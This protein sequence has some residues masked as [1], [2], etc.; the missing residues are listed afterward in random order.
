MTIPDNVINDLIAQVNEIDT[1]LGTDPAGVYSNVR[2][3]L[4]ILE[5]RVN[6]PFNPSPSSDFA[7]LNL[8]ELS[9][10]P[11]APDDDGQIVYLLSLKDA[12]VYHAASTLTVDGI[13]IVAANGSG[14]WERINLG[15]QEWRT[16]NTWYIDPTLGNDENN[17]LTSGTALKT[18]AELIRRWGPK[19]DIIQS[20]NIYFLGN[21]PTSDPI[22]LSEVAAPNNIL[23]NGKLTALATGTLTSYAAQVNNVS[24]VQIG[25]AGLVSTGFAPYVGKRLRFTSGAA[26]GMYV[27]IQ[28]DDGYITDGYKASVLTPSNLF[29]FANAA[30]G[31]TYVIEDLS[32]VT[33]SNISAKGT[34]D[35]TIGFVDLNIINSS[36]S[37]LCTTLFLNSDLRTSAIIKSRSVYLQSSTAPVTVT[38]VGILL[39]GLCAFFAQ[40]NVSGSFV[41]IFNDCAAIGQTACMSL[42][43]AS[44]VSVT[45]YATVSIQDGTAGFIVDEQSTL[46]LSNTVW[47]SNVGTGFKVINGSKIKT[48]PIISA[49]IPTPSE[50]LL[51]T[52]TTTN[53]V[54]DGVEKTYAQL[55]YFNKAS[56]SSID[57][58][59]Q[60]TAGSISDIVT[61]PQI[62]A[63]KND[64]NL[65]G[66]PAKWIRAET[67]LLSSDSNADGYIT[68]FVALT[69]DINKKTLVNTGSFN[70]V[71]QNMNGGSIAANQIAVSGGADLTLAPTNTVDIFYDIANSVWR[72]L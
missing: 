58:W 42:K 64:Y 61:A 14:R 35:S 68:G 23:F 30:P 52:T 15:S 11:I 2:I 46:S 37:T 39:I 10:M 26:S 6:N 34:D 20:T 60:F 12:F 5:S 1:E 69:S 63:P 49:P 56:G 29:G 65:D 31:D 27:W 45:P 32:Q 71:L 55:P 18:Y 50:Y 33:I 25:D 28:R 67:V 51:I 22:F 13:T 62:T 57:A 41:S 70:I 7:I 19:P 53:V 8:L 9:A 17:G 16:Q 48:G 44:I 36:I 38:D 47:G 72:T 40:L 54:L 3:R 43:R 59:A 66:N 24:L 4:D 21:M